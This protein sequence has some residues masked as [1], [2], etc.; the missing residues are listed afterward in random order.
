MN[1]EILIKEFKSKVCE[2]ITLIQEGLNRF[3][4]L[5]PF[6]FDDGDHIVVLLKFKNGEW[7][8]TDEG[9][10]FMH[11]SY[12]ELDL[13]KGTRKKIIDNILLNYGI[14][15]NAGELNS[16]IKEN[17]FGD[18][19]FSFFQGL[20]KITDVSFLRREIVRSTFMEDLKEYLKV[21]VP[22]ERRFF[23]YFDSKHDPTGKYIV[24]CKING[25][26]K[27]LFIF[28]IPNDD[29]CRDVTINCL[30]F[31]KF[32]VPFKSLAIFEDQE[33]INRKVLARLSDVCDKQFSSLISNKE[34]ID[35]YLEE[36]IT[37]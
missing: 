16:Y 31:E 36:V 27:P 15:N 2:E 20:I 30:Q 33:Q 32:G 9:H 17:N 8:L 35:K 14:K 25:I 29:K 24:D 22:A 7:Y 21:Q 4:I 28:G 6:I 12:D 23:N 19:L 5:N 37:H 26:E 1:I 3:I 34:R 11:L 13:D 10:T 18:T